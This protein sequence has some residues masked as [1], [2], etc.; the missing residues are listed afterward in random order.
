MNIR[1]EYAPNP[2]ASLLDKLVREATALRYRYEADACIWQAL[3][4]LGV[5]NQ[6]ERTQLFKK[7]KLQ[8]AKRVSEGREQRKDFD[9]AFAAANRAD[10]MRDAYRH[11]KNQPR[12]AYAVD[13]DEEKD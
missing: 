10:M 11:E 8:L 9:E 3:T 1:G 13:A 2:E 12:D 5:R 7:V 6:G 4:N